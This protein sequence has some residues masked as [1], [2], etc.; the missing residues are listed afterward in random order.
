MS[1]IRSRDQLKLAVPNDV[2]CTIN[3]VGQY[4]GYWSGL[5]Q[6]E[7]IFFY[8][9]ITQSLLKTRSLNPADQFVV[10]WSMCIQMENESRAQ[11]IATIAFSAIRKVLVTR[12]HEFLFSMPIALIAYLFS[13]RYRGSLITCSI[14]FLKEWEM[15]IKESWNTV[16][17]YIGVTVNEQIKDE[18]YT[19]LETYCVNGFSQDGQ[20]PAFRQLIGNTDTSYW[21][22]VRLWCKNKAGT[23][24]TTYFVIA[25][26]ALRCLLAPGTSSRLES[27]FSKMKIL[28]TS[29]RANMSS[30]RIV[31]EFI[32][33]Q[34]QQQIWGEQSDNTRSSRKRAMITTNLYP[35][36]QEDLVDLFSKESHNLESSSDDSVL[37]DDEHHIG[38]LP[39]PCSRTLR[40]HKRHFGNLPGLRNKVY[41]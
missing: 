28:S 8:L 35:F 1:V 30:D 7:A 4:L 2:V 13:P 40:N 3:E 10:F 11:G 33:R 32:I 12:M 20:Y 38:W 23:N 16:L 31:S 14:G 22:K 41:Q 37:L 34:A 18:M 9:S 36:K 17:Q 26:V 39:V 27:V 5:S 15:K 6:L 19:I 29:T 25:C 21:D 24:I